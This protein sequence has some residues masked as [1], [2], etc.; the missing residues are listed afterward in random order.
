MSQP[1]LK[2]APIS[3][4]SAWHGARNPP[5]D[6]RPSFTGRTVIVTG[7]NTGLGFEAAIKFVQL[8]AAK[9]IL[10]V[11]TIKKGEDAKAAIEAR[12]GRNDV[13]EVWHLDMLDYES[14]KA[15][16]ARAERE[17][18]RLDIAVLNAGILAARYEQS[19][20]GWEKT[21]QVNVLST[22]LLSL[23][24]LPKLRASKTEQQTPVLELVSSTIHQNIQRLGTDPHTDEGPLA[25]YNR[26]IG[27]VAET[28]YALSKLFLEHAHLAL[29]HLARN[30]ETSRPDVLVV[31]VCPGATQ[32]EITRDLQ[33]HSL[34]FRIGVWILARLFQRTTEEGA[35]S[36]VSA[37]EVGE[38]GHGRWF[39]D[40]AIKE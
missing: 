8:D 1:P 27:F 25:L 35:R 37:L 12:S 32:S 30:T 33:R 18:E 2:A 40:D 34:L 36:Y 20:Y 26:P 21:L 6:T 16:A 28:Q 4:I 19:T 24:L 3:I 31:S 38:A 11:R 14:I 22:T 10:G 9:V 39:M 23:L 7:A 17:L 29:A 13:V 5:K 15:F